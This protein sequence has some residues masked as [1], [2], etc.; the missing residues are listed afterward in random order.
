MSSET[1]IGG[2]CFICLLLAIG[3]ND[4][5]CMTPI[6][7]QIN[8]VT[9]LSELVGNY[10]HSLVQ[11]KPS[12]LCYLGIYAVIVMRQFWTK[13][14]SFGLHFGRFLHKLIWSPCN[15]FRR[16]LPVQG[17]TIRIKYQTFALFITC[18]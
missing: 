11:K 1:F 3:I 6:A 5:L 15:S 9:R 4:Q 18:H 14:N 8:K 2:N 17:K 16:S 13:K 12:R 10:E 7:E